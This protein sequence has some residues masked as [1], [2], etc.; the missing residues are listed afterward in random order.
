MTPIL[1]DCS[2]SSSD[3]L[4]AYAL[5]GVNTPPYV[6]VYFPDAIDSPTTLRN[7]TMPEDILAAFARPATKG[8]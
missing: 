1:V 4:E 7:V 2:S 6:F 8:P 5:H 3:V